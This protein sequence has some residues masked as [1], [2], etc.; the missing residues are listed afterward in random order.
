MAD[1]LTV[2][3]NSSIPGPSA[4]YGTVTINSG[5]TIMIEQQTTVTIDTLNKPAPASGTTTS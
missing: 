4:Q 1:N 2:P 5:G 3:P